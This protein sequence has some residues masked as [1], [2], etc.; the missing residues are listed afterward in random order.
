M[1]RRMPLSAYGDFM[2]ISLV[3]LRVECFLEYVVLR[4]SIFGRAHSRPEVYPRSAEQKAELH[5][6]YSNCYRK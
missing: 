4:Y 6:V 5:V 1:R 2:F 3:F